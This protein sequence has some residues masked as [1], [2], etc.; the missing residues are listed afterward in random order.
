MKKLI[1]IITVILLVP[2]VYGAAF[3]LPDSTYNPIIQFHMDENNPSQNWTNNSGS[4]YPRS[5]GTL[6]TGTPYSTGRWGYGINTSLANG[7]V[8]NGTVRGTGNYSQNH[9][10]QLWF[11]PDLTLN[12]GSIPATDDYLLTGTD[13]EYNTCAGAEC[14]YLYF[15]DTDGKLTYIDVSGTI[16]SIRTSWNN[17]TWY[18]AT[19]TSNSTH[20]AMYINGMYENSVANTGAA[21]SFN[22]FILGNYFDFDTTDDRC[23]DGIID[24]FNFFDYTLYE[25]NISPSIINETI[26]TYTPEP[27]ERST[28]TYTF[29]ITVKD[30]N[31]TPTVSFHYNGTPKTLTETISDQVYSYSVSVEHIEVAGDITTYP[32]NLTWFYNATDGTF[33]SKK[34]SITI[35]DTVYKILI[36]GCTTAVNQTINFTIRDLATNLSITDYDFEGIFRVWDVSNTNFVRN[37]TFDVNTISTSNKM[38]MFPPNKTFR[39]DY[40]TL[41]TATNYEDLRFSAYNVNI[42]ATPIYHYLY[43]TNSSTSTTITIQVVDENDNEL[44]GYIVEAYRYFLGGDE[45]DIVGSEITGS[46]GRISFN[47]DVDLYQYKFEVKNSNNTLVYTA[48]KQ[49]LTQTEYTFR[50]VV[51]V[52]PEFIQ[53]KMYSLDITLTADR[54]ANNFTVVWNDIDWAASQIRMIVYKTNLTNI[55]DD[56]DLLY[57]ETSTSASGRLNYTISDDTTNLSVVYTATVW[58]LSKD[59]GNEYSFDSK[60]IDYQK[61]WDIFGSNESL[62]ATFL[63]V[64]TMIFVGISVGPVIGILLTIFSMFTAFFLGFY[65]V[66]LSGLIALVAGLL[67]FVARMNRR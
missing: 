22:Y 30:G 65:M 52:L 44:E 21:A 25:V 8:G 58:V 64:G 9:S 47:L 14:I 24:E 5:N 42:S 4:Y 67:I 60:S 6:V 26:T 27:V 57:N 18:R 12:T 56:S 3:D 35:N 51:G 28:S 41:F 45:F 46:D 37:Y 15:D 66:G 36:D 17:E 16:K 11:K 63:Y 54:T 43:M 32:I 19:I 50:I 20:L 38:C 7:G 13:S 61:A 59:D 10:L 62:L 33:E 23:F 40:E 34:E 2:I 55:T 49:K 39:A 29:N 48:G 1:S 31:T 53:Q